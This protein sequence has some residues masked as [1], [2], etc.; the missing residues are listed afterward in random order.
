MKLKIEV[1]EKLGIDCDLAK[2]LILEMELDVV[3]LELSIDRA[4]LK[5]WS[6]NELRYDWGRKLLEV[7]RHR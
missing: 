6:G 4:W 2:K 7:E 1:H 5:R 3:K